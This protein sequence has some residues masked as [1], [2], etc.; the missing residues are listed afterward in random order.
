MLV[1][2]A[3]RTARTNDEISLPKFGSMLKPNL[4]LLTQEIHSITTLDLS[5]NVVPGINFFTS[6]NIGGLNRQH[7]VQLASQLRRPAIEIK[8]HL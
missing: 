7:C 1:S 5:G 8:F 2:S 3:I 4:L 6:T